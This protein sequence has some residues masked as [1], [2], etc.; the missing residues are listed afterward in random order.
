[1]ED[2]Y[3]INVAVVEAKDAVCGPQRYRH[4]FATRAGSARSEREGKALFAELCSAFPGPV[5]KVDVT[6]WEARG[7]Y[8]EWAP[9]RR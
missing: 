9:R 4:L 7:Y 1:M 2:G 6:K 5:Y 3:V 8:P